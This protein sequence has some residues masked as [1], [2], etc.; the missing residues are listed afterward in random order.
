MRRRRSFARRPRSMG[1]KRMDWVPATNVC[2]VPVDLVDCVDGVVPAGSPT[3]EY[4]LLAAQDVID[5][6]DKLTVLRVVG[7]IGFVFDPPLVGSTNI[8]DS[9]ASITIMEGVYVAD[10]DDAG[11]FLVHNAA[12][13]ADA[14]ASWMW[15]NM[16]ILSV[17]D[18]I[19]LSPAVGA[20]VTR[21]VLTTDVV[22]V[23]I[24]VKRKLGDRNLLLYT[25]TAINNSPQSSHGSLFIVGD[26]RTLVVSKG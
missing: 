7:N 22:H 13:G 11:S 17:H 14:E 20:T 16:R 23:D 6:T 9:K 10:T 21:S 18:M 12:L 26:L 4:S 1:S 5:H 8:V 2:G 24:P 15:R 19:D 3:F 25:C